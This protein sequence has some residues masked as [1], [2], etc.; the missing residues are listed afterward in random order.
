MTSESDVF[1]AHDRQEMFKRHTGETSGQDDGH[2]SDVIF[3][4]FYCFLSLEI[5]SFR[6][7]SSLLCCRINA[8]YCFLLTY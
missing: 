7:Y 8:T 5:I 4:F 2:E 1:S 6:S 3:F